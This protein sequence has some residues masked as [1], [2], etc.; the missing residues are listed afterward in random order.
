MRHPSLGRPS[1]LTLLRQCCAHH[2]SELRNGCSWPLCCLEDASARHYDIGASLCSSLH[3]AGIQ[4]A[5][6]L[7]V[8]GREAGAQRCHLGQ[9]V[10][11]EALPP[12]ARLHCHDKRQGDA[13]VRLQHW[14]QL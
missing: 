10:C 5:I 9:H 11:H 4:A 2:P 1:A 14:Q 6:H 8:Q 7:D 3:C 13:W 12:K